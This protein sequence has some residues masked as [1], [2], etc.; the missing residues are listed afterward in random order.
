[1]VE[2]FK[3][4]HVARLNSIRVVSSI[5]IKPEVVYVLIECENT[6]LYSD[7]REEDYMEKPPGYVAQREISFANLRRQF[8]V[9]S[10]VH[11]PDLTN[12]TE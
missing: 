3:T 1:M 4:S 9:S 12:L 10:R 8:M 7:L 6:F 11:G 2:Y 5:A